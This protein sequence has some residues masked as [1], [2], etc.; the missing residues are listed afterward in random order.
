MEG[1]LSGRLSRVED[2]NHE[3]YGE[4]LKGRVLVFPYSVGSLA[5]GVSLLEAIKQGVGPAAIVNVQTDGVLL[6]GPIFARVF[7][8][9]QV[10]VVDSLDGDPLSIIRNGDILKVDGD[11]GTVEVVQRKVMGTEKNRMKIKE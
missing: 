2:H 1:I 3:L 11:R 6:S 4:S 10:P 7:F 9:I 5:G 8:G